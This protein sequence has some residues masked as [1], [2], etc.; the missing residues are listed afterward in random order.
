M[1]SQRKIFPAVL[2]KKKQ[3]TYK[4]M[5]RNQLPLASC[6]VG[7]I[8]VYQIILYFLLLEMTAAFSCFVMQ[9]RPTRHSAPNWENIGLV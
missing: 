2:A 7:S 1:Y 9:D 6:E 3:Q 5:P 4:K 8:L